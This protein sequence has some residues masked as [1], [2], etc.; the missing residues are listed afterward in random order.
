M[1][2][3]FFLVIQLYIHFDEVIQNFPSFP[4]EI[5]E[6]SPRFHPAPRAMASAAPVPAMP[7]MSAGQFCAMRLN[8]GDDLKVF[9]GL[10]DQGIISG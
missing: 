5:G 10:G 3:I 7:A 8:P 4:N 1:N 2:S 6:S 9:G